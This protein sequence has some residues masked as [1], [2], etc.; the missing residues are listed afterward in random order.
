MGV[1]SEYLDR[2]MTGDALNKERKK[3][4]K[5][6]QKLRGGRDILVIAADLNAKGSALGYDDLVPVQDQLA[7]LSGDALDVILETPGG[8]GETAEDIIRIIRARYEKLGMI[9]P[10]WAKSAGTIMVMAGDEILLGPES[11]VGPIDAQLQWQ[12]KTFSADALLK[13]FEKIKGEVEKSGQ[14]NKAYIPILQGI[15]PGELEEAR[16]HLNFAKELVKSWLVSYKFKYWTTHSSTGDPVTDEEKEIRAEE[17]ADRLC[18]HGQWLVHGR[19]LKIS[20]L[21]DIGLKIDDY[22]AS[23]DLADAIRRYH[24]LLRMT[25]ESNVYKVFETPTSQIYRMEAAPAGMDIAGSKPKEA[26]GHVDFVCKK[27]G[28]KSRIQ[29]NLGKKQPLEK[30]SFPFPK[31]SVFKCP[32]CGTDHDVAGIRRQFEA[33]SQLP[34]VPG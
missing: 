25:L 13:G 20:D 18:D 31:T 22:S 16:N 21:T 30:G 33:Q 5:R 19:S 3:Q 29:A 9:V 15:S 6:I 2:R 26:Q 1:Y 34:L 24:A 4:L 28:R 14:L 11:A 32:G 23:P 8:S 17:I 7:N 27:C 10:G 12:G